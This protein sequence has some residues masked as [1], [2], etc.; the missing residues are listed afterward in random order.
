MYILKDILMR[1][2]AAAFLLQ[3][4]VPF[5]AVYG[6]SEAHAKAALENP[7]MFG[8]KVL[9]C[10]RDGFQYVSWE[11]LAEDEETRNSQHRNLQCPTCYVQA[12][13]M[14][15]DAPQP[16]VL[17]PILA[18]QPLSIAPHTAAMITERTL[19]AHAPRAPP[20]RA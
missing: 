7:E 11:T 12:K 13:D 9:I 8:D 18:P 19:R 10:T 15:M 2:T 14:H 17:K 5:Y 3:L 16:Y 1:F 6:V 20:V 4:L